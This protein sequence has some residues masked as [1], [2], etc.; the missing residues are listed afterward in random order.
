MIT[1]I[2]TPTLIGRTAIGLPLTVRRTRRWAS[3]P[4]RPID[5]FEMVVVLGGTGWFCTADGITALRRGMVLVIG[6]GEFRG[7]KDCAG[8]EYLEVRTEACLLSTELPS[9]WAAFESSHNRVAHLIA[10]S[11]KTRDLAL[12]RIEA[13]GSALM[14]EPRGTELDRTAR[15]GYLALI[16]CEGLGALESGSTTDERKTVARAEPARRVAS[17]TATVLALL[18]NSPEKDWNLSKLSREV[19]LAPE[20]MVRLFRRDVGASPMKYLNRLRADR[21]SDLLL[22]TDL[23]VAAITRTLGWTDAGYASRRFRQIFGMSP[24]QYRARFRIQLAVSQSPGP[25]RGEQELSI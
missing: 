22:E 5:W 12:A 8:L 18:Q 6:P 3:E 10:E 24:L 11:Q 2:L 4:A 20:Y 1:D 21:V 19:N 9:L 23:P 15:I 14:T 25:S 17:S 13:W 16:L 7:Y